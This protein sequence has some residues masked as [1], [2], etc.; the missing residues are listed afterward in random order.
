MPDLAARSHRAR[1]ARS[2]SLTKPCRYKSLHYSNQ[3]Q[4]AGLI[5]AQ[6]VLHEG[7]CNICCSYCNEFTGVGRFKRPARSAAQKPIFTI[8]LQKAMK[9]ISETISETE[10]AV[11]QTS[12]IVFMPYEHDYG[13]QLQFIFHMY[14]CCLFPCGEC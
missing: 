11:R 7:A 13:S 10:G 4:L 9:A 5:N 14:T 3:K 1:D 8:G 6:P 2:R 12:G